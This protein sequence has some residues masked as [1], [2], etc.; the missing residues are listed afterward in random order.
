MSG[1]GVEGGQDCGQQE[2]QRAFEQAS[3]VVAGGGEDGV[4]GVAVGFRRGDL[5]T[6]RVLGL[7]VSDDRFDCRSAAE[8]AFDGLCDAASLARDIELELVVGRSGVATI[9]AVGDDAGKD[10]A[11]IGQR[12]A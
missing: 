9:A 11:R 10:E 8:F 3:E 4:G 7:G 2:S 1:G 6:I 12:E 5:R